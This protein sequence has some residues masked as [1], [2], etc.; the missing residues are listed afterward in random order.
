M[1][2]MRT[3]FSSAT[4]S[5]CC[6]AVAVGL[7]IQVV[8]VPPSS[9]ASPLPQG[10][11]AVRKSLWPLKISVGAGLLAKASSHS[12]SMRAD[13]TL[14]RASPLPQGICAV[15][16]FLWPLKIS[17]GAS[18]LAKASSNSTSMQAD[19]TLSRASPLPQGICAVRKFL[20][21]LKINVG[22]GLLAK[23]SS[24]S[25]SMRADPTLSRASS[26]PQGNGGVDG[27]GRYHGK[28]FFQRSKR[29]PITDTSHCSLR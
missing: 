15:R 28:D 18:L 26:L 8:T 21:P 7:L 20:W 9:R 10:V 23:A 4:R 29:Q 1:S 24:H 12:T 14:S 16:K 6:K 22:A 2:S 13:P 3:A 19:P 5:A 17:V 25:T 11:C 27:F